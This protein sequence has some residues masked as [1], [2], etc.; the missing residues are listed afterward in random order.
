MTSWYFAIASSVI[1]SSIL[2]PG[3]SD[4]VPSMLSL[5]PIRREIV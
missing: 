3:S 5:I 4:Q 2:P 1:L